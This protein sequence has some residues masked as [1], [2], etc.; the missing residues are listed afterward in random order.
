MGS[1]LIL[2]LVCA[3]VL[4]AGHTALH[5]DASVRL[6]LARVAAGSFAPLLSPSSDGDGEPRAVS[7]RSFWLMTR[8]V[9]ND[10]FLAFVSRH[11]RYRRDNIPR[12]FADAQ[13]LMRFETPTRL[14]E[15][16]GRCSRSRS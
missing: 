11:P 15:A 8:P 5:A 7:V 12:A 9:R 6:P 14:E 13:Y 2:P 1:R 10:E 4:C 16:P 3:L